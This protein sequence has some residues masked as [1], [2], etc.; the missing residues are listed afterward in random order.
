MLAKLVKLKNI[1]GSAVGL[2]GDTD[3]AKQDA[4]DKKKEEAAK[5]MTNLQD[6]TTKAV[7][8]LAKL[9]SS[10]PRSSTKPPPSDSV[11]RTP[12]G[13]P[14]STKELNR[15]V[16]EK[17]KAVEDLSEAWIDD[18]ENETEMK[19]ALKALYLAKA[20]AEK[21]ADG[22][23]ATNN[24]PQRYARPRRDKGITKIA[25]QLTSLNGGKLERISPFS[26]GHK[27][28]DYFDFFGE[29]IIV[30]PG[31]FGK[32]GVGS[33]VGRV[34]A[35]RYLS[36]AVAPDPLHPA[37]LFLRYEYV[38]SSKRLV[39]FFD[40]R[41]QCYKQGPKVKGPPQLGIFWLDPNENRAE[42]YRALVMNGIVIP[43]KGRDRPIP[44]SLKWACSITSAPGNTTQM[45]FT[46]GTTFVS[47]LSGITT[48]CDIFS[49]DPHDKKQSGWT[50][51]KFEDHLGFA[52]NVEFKA[53]DARNSSYFAFEMIGVGILCIEARL[54][55]TIKIGAVTKRVYEP[56]R[57]A[58]Y[59]LTSATRDDFIVLLANEL[60]SLAGVCDL[61]PTKLYTPF[62]VREEAGEKTFNAMWAEEPIPMKQVG[63][64]KLDIVS[65]IGEPGEWHELAAERKTTSVLIDKLSEAMARP[66][67][68]IAYKGKEVDGICVIFRAYSRK[69]SMPYA[70]CM[71][72]ALDDTFLV[73]V[74][75]RLFSGDTQLTPEDH[76]PEVLMC[77]YSADLGCEYGKPLP[78]VANAKDLALFTVDTLGGGV[79]AITRQGEHGSYHRFFV[80]EVA[81]CTT[82]ASI[83]IMRTPAFVLSEKLES[84]FTD[85]F[86]DIV[87]DQ[88]ATKSIVP[89]GETVSFSFRLSP[90]ASIAYKANQVTSLALHPE[91]SRV[92]YEPINVMCELRDAKGKVT[93]MRNPNSTWCASVNGGPDFA[94][95]RT[96]GGSVTGLDAKLTTEALLEPFAVTVIGDELKVYFPWMPCAITRTGD[97]QET[98]KT[99]DALVGDAH[100][101]TEV[102]SSV[103]FDPIDDENASVAVEDAEE[104]DVKVIE[105]PSTAPASPQA[106]I[107]LFTNFDPANPV[108]RPWAITDAY[109]ALEKRGWPGIRDKACTLT[110]DLTVYE[111]TLEG[112]TTGV[113]IAWDAYKEKKDDT[114]YRI[115]SARVDVGSKVTPTRYGYIDAKQ[116]DADRVC[117]HVRHCG[118]SLR[119]F[120]LLLTTKGELAFSKPTGKP[121]A[122]KIGPTS[123]TDQHNAFVNVFEGC[124]VKEGSNWAAPSEKVKA[125]GCMS[126]APFPKPSNDAIACI[127]V[128]DATKKPQTPLNIILYLIDG[129]FVVRTAL[130]AH[131]R[132]FAVREL[133]CAKHGAKE[134]GYPGAEDYFNNTTKKM[135]NNNQVTFKQ[136]SSIRELNVRQTFVVGGLPVY[137]FDSLALPHSVI[138]CESHSDGSY[139][140]VYV[141]VELEDRR[142]APVFT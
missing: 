1:V 87:D 10:K 118:M 129:V 46:D 23:R 16:I 75:W 86:K 93:S 133:V 79:I 84:A 140:I 131:E 61:Q 52:E 111:Y 18:D 116:D 137:R 3:K 15:V 117:Y 99:K 51:L 54:L 63:K 33:T 20:E 74:D 2:G 97:G 128:Y 35:L 113:L 50:D 34:I 135:K 89:K 139:I 47:A 105:K 78:F 31:G 25:Y 45:Q 114:R 132:A 66:V 7:S 119:K 70:L 65:S 40:W 41:L 88:T 55:H 4:L 130:D 136:V 120:A 48:G 19:I 11:P 102:P 68:N 22:D 64:F 81:P 95:Y 141:A 9:S 142:G 67:L 29:E 124:E 138:T 72:L 101:I 104:D 121:F 28:T 53:E 27:I 115:R 82:N 62:V 125:F 98:K 91:G 73:K 38:P 37:V 112:P 36:K 109:N 127:E 57:E 17:F 6:S 42:V 122:L 96:S 12:R 56:H 94:D 106:V 69:H 92:C 107:P 108:N 58:C 24:N 80:T 103:T 39:T 110:K 60:L 43:E 71:C 49:Y 13:L 76:M 77:L 85:K 100:S 5:T 30:E 90:T 123:A 14:K 134:E 59:R 32:Q 26:D 8:I 126:D 83:T 21:H 44:H